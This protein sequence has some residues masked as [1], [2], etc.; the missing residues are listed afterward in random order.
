MKA[1]RRS[2]AWLAAGRVCDAFVKASI[3]GEEL[4][5]PNGARVISSDLVTDEMIRE[6]HQHGQSV[7]IVDEHEN[8]TVLPAPDPS[9]GERESDRFW[10]EIR[11]QR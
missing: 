10:D 7:A 1:S 8:V 5:F 6:S 4:P 3:A 9:L 2:A 11:A